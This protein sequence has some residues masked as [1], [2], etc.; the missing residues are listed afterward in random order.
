[1]VLL[2]F[3]RLGAMAAS[4]GMELRHPFFD[5]RVIEHLLA[6]P[7]EQRAGVEITKPVLRRALGA[8]LPPIVRWRTT[9]SEATDYYERAFLGQH[10]AA[11]RRLLASSRLADEG[12]IDRRAV[13]K[14]LDEPSKFVHHVLTVTSLELWL[15]QS[16]PARSPTEASHAERE[17]GS[18]AD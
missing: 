2:C 1:D 13:L 11:V 3:S 8:D 4:R 5:I 17:S 7:D 15:R 14:L 6:L 10:G 16:I 12:L 9:W 18:R